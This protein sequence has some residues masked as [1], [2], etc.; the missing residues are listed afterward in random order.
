MKVLRNR[1][2]FFSKEENR[3]FH[4]LFYQNGL[5]DPRLLV[6]TPIELISISLF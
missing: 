3:H 2:N 6:Q 1:R 4:G 5:A